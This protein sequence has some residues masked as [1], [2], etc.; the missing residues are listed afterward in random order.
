M[1][2]IKPSFNMIVTVGDLLRNIG[3]VSPISRRLMETITVTYGNDQCY[4]NLKLGKCWKEHVLRSRIPHS[5]LVHDLLTIGITI[6]FL[7][8]T[9]ALNVNF[10]V[11][12][13]WTR[14]E[15]GFHDS[16]TNPCRHFFNCR[17]LKLCEFTKR[18]FLI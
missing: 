5:I 12:K 7:K 18:N 15:R 1:S 16:H 14:M 2:C 17:V 6:Q 8:L 10:N 11:I 4:E 3:D 13:S 9:I